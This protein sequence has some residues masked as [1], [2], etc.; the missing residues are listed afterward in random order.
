MEELYSIEDPY[1]YLDRLTMPKY[2][3][4]GSGDQFFCPDSSQF[5]YDELKG[6]KHIRYV[7][8]ARHN[9]GGSDAQESMSVY[10]Q[11]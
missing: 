7:P 2:I 11:E 6:E 1:Y 4:N 9:L 10:A 5:Y 3:V 8:N